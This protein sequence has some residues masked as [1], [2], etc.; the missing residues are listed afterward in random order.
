MGFFGTHNEGTQQ[1]RGLDP[2]PR[3]R[4]DR[5]LVALVRSAE[6]EFGA[7]ALVPFPCGH[8]CMNCGFV[9]DVVMGDALRTDPAAPLPACPH[10]RARAW[11]DLADEDVVRNLAE[12]ERW[13]RAEA[14]PRRR[15]WRIGLGM[16]LAVMLGATAIHALIGAQYYA[17][18]FSMLTSLFAILFVPRLVMDAIAE[19]RRKPRQ[20][21][22]RWSLALPPTTAEPADVVASGPVEPGGEPLSAPL[23]GRACVAYEVR[24]TRPGHV[25]SRAPTLLEQRCADFRVG[26]FAVTGARTLLRLDPVPLTPADASGREAIVER[27]LRSHGVLEDE[28]P[29]QLHETCVEVGDPVLV[30]A[31]PRGGWMLRR[32][33]ALAASPRR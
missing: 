24:V 17:V 1:A 20:I 23:T 10:C 26:D 15:A 25:S 11:A 12:L 27:Y 9:R 7:S 19:A 22:Y 29:W 13:E 32:Q 4:A 2:R 8:V 16:L 5:R 33:A 18:L 28:G 3:A 14:D 21:P 31:D 30:H 6:S